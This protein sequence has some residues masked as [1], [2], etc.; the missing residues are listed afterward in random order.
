MRL[1]LPLR[2]GGGGGGGGGGA[3]STDGAQP[4]ATEV[5]FSAGSLSSCRRVSFSDLI[6]VSVVLQP[7]GITTR[8]R[9]TSGFEA[10]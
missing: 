2:G 4:I 1:K 3:A 9:C 6:G 5:F 10:L 7:A 8:Q